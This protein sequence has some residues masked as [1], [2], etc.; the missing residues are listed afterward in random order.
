ME[1]WNKIRK[2]DEEF[3]KGIYERTSEYQEHPEASTEDTDGPSS[4]S[5][6]RHKVHTG[7]F[8]GA[9]V[10]A[11]C[12]LAGLGIT[13]LLPKWLHQDSA[14]V[15]E[16]AMY[17]SVDETEMASSQPQEDITPTE[18][19]PMEVVGTIRAVEE[20]NNEIIL[21][22][23]V[24]SQDGQEMEA[25]IEVVISEHLY[26]Q[27]LDYEQEQGVEVLD[28]QQVLL[29]VEKY[30]WLEYFIL[31]QEDNFYLFAEEEN[32]EVIYRNIDGDEIR[33]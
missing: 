21:Q 26:Q 16:S 29:Y 25:E 13:S 31:N 3:I 12:I 28:G 11:A 18:V 15:P 5:R 23:N 2:S 14:S 1:D 19:I 27:L 4:F 6:H 22:V 30:N 32:G 24:D 10:A 9:S 33:Y 7:I 8:K 20:N 17:R